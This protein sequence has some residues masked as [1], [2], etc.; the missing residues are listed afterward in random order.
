MTDYGPISGAIVWPQ[1]TGTV[2]SQVD[3][4]PD[5]AGWHAAALGSPGPQVLEGL[6]LTHDDTNTEVDISRGTA[7]VATSANEDVQSSAGG[8]FDHTLVATEQYV[9]S[10][11]ATTQ[12][13]DDGAVNDIY[14]YFDPTARDDVYLRIGSNVSEPSNPS[15]RLGQVDDSLWTVSEANRKPTLDL[16]GGSTVSHTPSASDDIADKQYVDNEVSGVSGGG[17]EW[18]TLDTNSGVFDTDAGLDFS[19]SG[20][21]HDEYK[22]VIHKMYPDSGVSNDFGIVFNFEH[23]FSGSLL[24]DCTAMFYD[25]TTTTGFDASNTGLFQRL[26]ASH[27]EI[28]IGNQS[29]SDAPRTVSVDVPHTDPGEVQALSTTTPS[30]SDDVDELSIFPE[31][32][33]TDETYAEISVKG[34]SF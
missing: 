17:A 28:I 33:T 16:G 25:G 24:T 20:S 8:S 10:L 31:G 34:R 3:G 4:S 19:F 1:D 18:T 6:G 26:S 9:V 29:N 11:P 21:T 13:I 5:S 12:S 30:A 27:G 7:L 22:V 2:G 15:I 32:L 14:L 23:E